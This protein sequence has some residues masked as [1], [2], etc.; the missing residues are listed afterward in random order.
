MNSVNL[1]NHF[2]S[3]ISCTESSQNKTGQLG[4]KKITSNFNLLGKLK[5]ASK[6]A[7][8]ALAT[9]AI[10]NAPV[11]DG[12]AVL[13]SMCIAACIPLAEAPPLLALCIAA[14]TPLLAPPI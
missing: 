6:I 8:L 13:Y 5:V 3:P 2:D 11:A 7:P 9:I 14:C 4:G 12:G 10:M 1:Q